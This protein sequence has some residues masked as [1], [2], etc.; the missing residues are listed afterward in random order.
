MDVMSPFS[1]AVPLVSVVAPVFN[2]ARTL[3]EFVS[4]LSA[5][6]DKLSPR[7]CFEFVLVDDGSTDDSLKQAKL[8]AG[9]EPRL[10]IIEL[11]RNF[12]QTA[13]LQAGLTS[14]QGDI[15]VSLDS[16][17][18]HFPE[19]MPRLL[20]KLEE[21]FDLVCGWRADRREGLL[22]RW[23]SS[24]ANW[25]I[26][27]VT[28]LRIHDFG[29]TYRVY[30]SDLVKQ[31]KLLGEQHRFVP[32]LAH[33][34]GARV[35]E[36]PIQNIERPVGLSNYGLGRTFGVALDIVYLY[37]AT[38]YLN[39]PLKA[40]GKLAAWFFVVGGTIFAVLIIWAY[41]AGIA[42]VR[43]RSGWFLLSLLLLMAGL[44]LLLAGILAEIIV[45]I[46]YGITGNN[47]Y[48][49]RREWSGGVQGDLQRFGER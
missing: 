29:T 10:R 16:D 11:R 9:T 3:T 12:G 40:F 43:E 26:R 36:V 34:V 13:A 18:Q 31:L 37:F 8:L 20:L 1:P 6:A 38:R 25:L 33:I 4:R 22:R 48:V 39:R 35:A 21:G 5:T 47:G 19:D 44:Q 7:Y 30:R 45:R 24:V 2:E 41:A 23:P 17:L 28:G 42:T 32:A 14:A 46:Y 49:V 27:R 15:V